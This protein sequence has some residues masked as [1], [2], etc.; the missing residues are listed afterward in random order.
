ML[1]RL[2]GKDSIAELCRREGIAQKLYC[3]IDMRYPKLPQGGYVQFAPQI[4]V[5]LALA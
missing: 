4:D 3:F 2:R 5:R 1:A